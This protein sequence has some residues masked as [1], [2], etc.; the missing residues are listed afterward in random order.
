MSR[1]FPSMAAA[2]ADLTDP[3][4][5]ASAAYLFNGDR[6]TV[7]R[8][9]R[10]EENADGGCLC[11][12]EDDGMSVSRKHF[13]TIGEL[14]AI[15]KP[16]ADD[17]PTYVDGVAAVLALGAHRSPPDNNFAEVGFDVALDHFPAEVPRDSN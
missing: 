5:L 12:F 10:D 4:D 1:Y 3:D 6:P 17:D 2:L 11:I 8:I 16:E 15:L 7:I 13:L 9:R 14:A